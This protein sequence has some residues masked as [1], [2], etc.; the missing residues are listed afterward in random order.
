MCCEFYLAK[1]KHKIDPKIIILR[2][3]TQKGELFLPYISLFVG[4]PIHRRGFLIVMVRP[5]SSDYVEPHFTLRKF[6]TVKNWY[7]FLTARE[8]LVPIR[9]VFHINISHFVKNARVVKLYVAYMR[10]LHIDKIP[11]KSAAF[12]IRFQFFTCMV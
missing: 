10:I 11:H 6:H 4:R 7:Q 9:H 1:Y 12:Y 5:R 2:T 3:K 8:K